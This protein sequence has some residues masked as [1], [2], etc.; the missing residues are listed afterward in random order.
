MRSPGAAGS[1]HVGTR[2]SARSRASEQ[3]RGLCDSNLKKQERMRG[4][5]KRMFLEP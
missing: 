4:D 1:F 2:T 3:R 5:L